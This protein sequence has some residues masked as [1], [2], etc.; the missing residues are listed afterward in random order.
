MT[1][2]FSSFQEFLHM[3]GLGVY[4]WTCYV[5]TF[6]CVLGLIIYVRGERKRTIVKLR[7]HNQRTSKLTN[8]QRQALAKG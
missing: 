8:K 2:Y 4:V 5:I 7:R 3:G 1:P 6:G